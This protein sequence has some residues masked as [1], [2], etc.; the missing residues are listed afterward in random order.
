MNSSSGNT[1]ARS[2]RSRRRAISTAPA[3]PISYNS[4]SG[5]VII[6]IE[7]TSAPGDSTA[8]AT[9]ESTTAYRRKR[10]SPA[11]VTTPRAARMMMTQRKLERE[12]EREDDLQ[13]EAEPG[14]VGDHRLQRLGLEA[15]E[16]PERLRHHEDV[17]QAGPDEEQPEAHHERREDDLPL[18]VVQRRREERP[19][20]V[21]EH[22]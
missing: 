14:I 19:G 16:H 6:S 10:C 21:D 3:T 8:P 9:K 13:H 1:A 18:P 5:T 22:G 12:A 7:S 4:S 20:L 11:G 15:E 17:A 2:D